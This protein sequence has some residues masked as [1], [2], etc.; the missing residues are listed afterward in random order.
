MEMDCE[1]LAEPLVKRCLAPS[2]VVTVTVCMALVVL[3]CPDEAQAILESF[4]VVEFEQVA[5]EAL[6]PA[7]IRVALEIS[8]E[9]DCEHL[10][11]PMVK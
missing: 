6:G 5:W 9:M 8:M 4:M 2:K 3:D 7:W 10:V 1:Y 11:E